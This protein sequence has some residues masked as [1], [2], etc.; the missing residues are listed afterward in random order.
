MTSLL[1]EQAGPVIKGIIRSKLNDRLRGEEAED[2]YCEVV[3]QL[4]ERLQLCKAR[5]V[6]DGIRDFRNYVAVT[7]YNACYE[8]LRSKYPERRRL[9]NRLKYLLTHC[10]AFSLWQTPE[11][12]WLGGFAVWATRSVEV[13]SSETL[14]ELHNAN[15][16]RVSPMTGPD[17]SSASLVDLVEAIFT[18]VSAPVEF[19]A[20][21]N[22][23]AELQGIKDFSEPTSFDEQYVRANPSETFVVEI[24]QRSYLRRLWSEIVQLPLNQRTALLLNLRDINDGVVMLLPVTGIATIRQIAETLEIPAEE[25]SNLWNRLPLD[26]AAI[27]L[28]LGVARQAVINLRKSARAR[29]CR[30]MRGI[31]P[32]TAK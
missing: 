14:R 15:E 23:V 22:S 24:E 7:T 28:R 9:K 17:V 6:S 10:A 18:K 20:L 12:D 8:Y 2:V 27:A 29:L 4:V 16:L 32:G 30:R 13:A 3:T 26:D 25:F 5:P 19:E 21:V 11:G 1:E 31:A